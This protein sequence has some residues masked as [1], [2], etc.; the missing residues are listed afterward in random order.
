MSVIGLFCAKMKF[1]VQQ[2]VEKLKKAILGVSLGHELR[3][4]NEGMNQR[5]LKNWADVANKICFS[6]N[7][8][9]GIGIEFWAVQ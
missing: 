1:F 7:L 4:P 2:K 6:R 8:K 3:T 5:Y 9:F